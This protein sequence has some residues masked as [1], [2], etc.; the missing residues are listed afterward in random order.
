M[1]EE[2]ELGILRYGLWLTFVPPWCFLCNKQTNKQTYFTLEINLLDL[3]FYYETHILLP[4]P[5]L[6]TQLWKLA[7]IE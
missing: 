4:T 2:P 1:K 7:L 6:L 5:L 3:Q